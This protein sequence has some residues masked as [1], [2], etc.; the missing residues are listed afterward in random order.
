MK[1][2]NFLSTPIL[3]MMLIFSIAIISQGYAK[4]ISNSSHLNHDKE[5]I[6]NQDVNKN[7]SLSDDSA[8]VLDQ[9]QLPSNKGNSQNSSIRDQE[10]SASKLTPR[11]DKLIEEKMKEESKKEL[12]YT[13]K[14]YQ[15]HKSTEVKDEK[16]R[17][18]PKEAKKTIK[19]DE[20]KDLFD[21][22]IAKIIQTYKKK[23]EP[24]KEIE[25]DEASQGESSPSNVATLTLSSSNV[26]QG[27]SVAFYIKSPYKIIKCFGNVGGKKIPFFNANEQK[28]FRGYAGFDI[29]HPAGN[30]KVIVVV[31][32][33]NKELKFLESELVVTPKY[34]RSYQPVYT[35]EQQ[36]VTKWFKGKDGRYYRKRIRSTVATKK[37]TTNGFDEEENGE[38]DHKSK[39]KKELARDIKIKEEK[40]NVLAKNG[41]HT[42]TN[43]KD[44]GYINSDV[45]D[46]YGLDDNK[47]NRN[48]WKS[49]SQI[50]EQNVRVT[51]PQ[52]YWSGPFLQP[53]YPGRTGRMSSQFG[54][55]RVFRIYGRIHSGHHRGLDIAQPEGTPLYAPNHG[56]VVISDY[57][58]GHGN[59]VVINHGGGIY[60]VQIHMSKILVKKGVFVRKGQLIGLVGTTG[61]ST[62]PHLHWEIR[63]NGVSVNPLQW[64]DY[65]FIKEK[66]KEK[67]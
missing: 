21:D 53:T 64:K 46:E 54:Q 1:K 28:V 16:T 55:Y 47:I 31:L 41:Y 49:E 36:W 18:E 20:V 24:S 45:L 35:Y 4:D 48:D 26:R 9:D 27:E 59:S 62:G 13:P 61:F 19:F 6:S 67:E 3:F 8:T 7:K 38:N 58:R 40:L 29:Q 23:S 14:P 2:L 65:F 51:T 5:F 52:T 44:S 17:K 63:V 11:D 15:V 60:S 34:A 56:M 42:I 57:F 30:V 10:K 66:D 37:S 12:N 50:F 22:E 33:E 25:L 39:I 32:F 43:P